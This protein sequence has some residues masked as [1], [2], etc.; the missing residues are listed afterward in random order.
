MISLGISRSGALSVC[1][2]DCRQLR[3][4]AVFPD[5]GP[6]LYRLG[7]LLNAAG[8]GARD[9]VAQ[10]VNRL[11]AEGGGSIIIL[12]LVPRFSNIRLPA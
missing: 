8:Q 6:K 3:R 5:E 7:R 2:L 11:I 10:D 4:A 1:I 9:A 12:A